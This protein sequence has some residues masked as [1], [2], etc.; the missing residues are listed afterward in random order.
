MVDSW[1]M[2]GSPG[3]MLCIVGT[4]LAF[5][6]KVG[7]KMMEKRPAFQLNFLLIAYNAFQVLFSIWLT[8]RSLEPGVGPLIFS[9]KCNSAN[10][11][12]IDINVQASVS[13][14]SSVVVLYREDDRA[15]RHRVLRAAQ[16]AKPSDLLARL[17]PH[18]DLGVL[19]VLPEIS[20]RRTGCSDR[21]PQFFRAHR[22]VLVLP[23]RSTWPAIQ[24]IPVVEEIHDRDPAGNT[25]SPYN[26]SPL[27]RRYAINDEHYSA[28][29]V[30]FLIMLGYL[31]MVLAMDCK[32]PKALTYFF[33]ANV[34]IFI[35]LFLDF[36]RKAYKKKK[37]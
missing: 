28:L 10:R 6:L 20:S 19:L 37:V 27:S 34:V 23:D 22:H 5:V 36:Y 7:P 29:Q 30:Q 26:F 1:P 15:S 21:Y 12:P 3:P 33:L 18:D 11:T 17:P 16:E 4:Y 25:L 35:Y 13:I 14:E 32:V 8:L 31:M 24:E 9:P 2:M